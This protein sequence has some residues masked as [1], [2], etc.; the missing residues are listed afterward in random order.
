MANKNALKIGLITGSVIA[1]P[2]LLGIGIGIGYAT[3][4]NVKEA[5]YQKLDSYKIFNNF[6]T[7]TRGRKAGNA[8]NFI[9]TSLVTNQV[10]NKPAYYG[11]KLEEGQTLT[12]EILQPLFPL[13]TDISQ[14][15]KNILGSYRAHEILKKTIAEMGYANVGDEIT[16]YPTQN[17]TPETTP[18]AATDT[19]ITKLNKS[20]KAITT[21]NSEGSFANIVTKM[22]TALTQ[23]GFFT[24]GFLYNLSPTSVNNVGTNVVVTINPT[25]TA[26]ASAKDFYIVSHYDSTNNV[27]PK[28]NSWGATDNAS[29]VSVNLGLLKYFSD[30]KNRENLGVRLHII[31]VDAEELG[32]LGSE[33][34]VAQFLTSNI[35]ENAE[36][37][38]LLANSI[39]MINMDTVAGG[40]RM[41]VHSPNTNPELGAAKG[42]LSTI[43]RD[44]IN[45][46]SRIRSVQLNKIEEELEIHPMF[47]AGEYKPGETGDWSDHAPFYIKAKLPVAYIE[48]TDFSVKAKSGLYDGYAQTNNPAA[49]LRQGDGELLPTKLNMRKLNNGIIE[50]WDYPGD[51]GDYLVLGDIWHS[52]LDTPAWVNE[53]QGAKF[54]KQLDTVLETLKAYLVSMYEIKGTTIEYFL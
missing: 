6:I 8:N 17:T 53:H 49:W 19:T 7:Q 14:S 35:V 34:F 45:A 31:F 13:T 52:D 38:S 18:T 46:V 44:Q 21:F 26:K 2:A 54:Y 20:G 16:T 9:A 41:Y 47:S 24:Q 51:K 5:D 43:I 32:K 22:N 42:N 4:N 23:D 11:I 50:L 15:D 12:S 33:A 48:S 3:K 30:P 25:N 10:E 39:G 37:N 40:N 36:Q 27:G 28:G 29:G 1:V